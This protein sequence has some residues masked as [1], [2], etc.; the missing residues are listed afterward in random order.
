MLLRTPPLHFDSYGAWHDATCQSFVPLEIR[1]SKGAPF[2]NTAANEA[3][4]DLNVTELVTAAQQV[5]RTRALASRAERRIYKA[6]LQLAGRSILSQEGRSAVL[7]PGEWGVYDTA[8]PYEVAVEQGAHFLVLQI[9]PAHVCV[10]EPYLQRAVGRAFSAKRG[11]ARIA[12]NTLRLALSETPSLSAAA[13][14]DIAGSILQMMGLNICEQL[15]GAGMS[16]L[17]EV[18]HAQFRSICQHI[19][20]HLHDPALS[21]DS[22]AAHFRI[23]R[24]YLYKLFESQGLAPAD[25]IQG[26]RLERCRSLLS[27]TA[28]LRQI[29]E[30]AY[31]HGFADSATFSHAFRRRFGLSPT[32]WRRQH[33]PR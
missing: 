24:R 4:G 32:Q 1:A 27:D 33:N 25:H 20:E 30:I 9:A 28:V 5:C 21:V 29:S 8:R 6:T 13:R 26:L 17:D 2:L 18:R 3:L 12:M 22:V 11:S 31:Q 15:G 23:S 14:R 7:R 16:D 10:W 19:D